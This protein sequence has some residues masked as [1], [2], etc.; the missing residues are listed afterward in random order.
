MA[1]YQWLQAHWM[2]IGLGWLAAQTFLKS[3]QDAIDAEPKGLTAI[4]RILYYMQAIGGYLF[5]G[6]RVQPIQKTGV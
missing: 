6:N 3:V 4:N 1:I 5:A 2:Q